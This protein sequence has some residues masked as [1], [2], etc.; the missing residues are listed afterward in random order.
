[1]AKAFDYLPTVGRLLLCSLFIW[2]GYVKLMHPVSTA[3]YF[4]N[5]GVAAPGLMVWVAI[6]VELAGGVAVLVGFKIRWAAAILAAWTLVTGFAVH[7]AVALHSADAMAAYDNMI[8]FYKNL[9]I[10][11]GLLYVVAFGAGPLS[12]DNRARAR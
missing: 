11:G 5:G 2:S 6:V 8:H 4:A 7:L 3:D 12:V 1:M 10:A 9:V